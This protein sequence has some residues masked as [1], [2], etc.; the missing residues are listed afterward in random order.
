M[1]QEKITRSIKRLRIFAG[2][3]GSGKSTLLYKLQNRYDLGVVVNADMISAQLQATGELGFDQFQLSSEASEFS[4]FCQ[5]PNNASFIRKIGKPAFMIEN[6]RCIVPK[7]ESCDLGYY[8]A[9]IAGFIRHLL[10]RSGLSF[11]YETVLSH[12]SK[13][14]EIMDA[15]KQGYRIYIYYVCLDSPDVS[16]RRVHAR[17]KMGGHNVETGKIKD[18]YTRSLENLLP[19]LLLSHRAYLFD[20]SKQMEMISEFEE[21]RLKLLRDEDRMPNW[22]SKYIRDRLESE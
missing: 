4:C 14:D 5:S 1:S 20:N 21:P 9:L 19:A 3:N 15:R 12:H 22:F 10:C 2:P 16:V 8:A 7:K 18:R 6:N 17:V 13:I 11:S